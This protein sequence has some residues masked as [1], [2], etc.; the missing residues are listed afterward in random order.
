MTQEPITR[1]RLWLPRTAAFLRPTSEQGQDRA[2]NL[3]AA[4]FMLGTALVWTLAPV[5]LVISDLDIPGVSDALGLSND[6]GGAGDRVGYQN[7]FSFNAGWRMGGVVGCL[8]FLILR[9]HRLIAHLFTKGGSEARGKIAAAMGLGLRAGDSN[10][11]SE[12]KGRNFGGW[13]ILYGVLGKF[14]YVLLAFAVSYATVISL[15]IVTIIYTVWPIIFIVIMATI[16]KENYKRGG[17][18]TALMVLLCF[19]G[20]AFAGWHYIQAANFQIYIGVG[21]AVLAALLVGSHYA[22][23]LKWAGSLGRSLKDLGEQLQQKTGLSDSDD[24]LGN[25]LDIFAAGSALLLTQLIC[26]II[27]FVVGMRLGEN[28]DLLLLWFVGGFLSAGV[29]DILFRAANVVSDN[30][31]VNAIIYAMPIFALALLAIF[32]PDFAIK[33]PDYFVI[34]VLIIIVSN[35]FINSEAE[36][37]W[38]FRSLIFTLG[39]CG[40]FVYFRGNLFDYIGLDQWHWGVVEYFGVVG[41][42]ATVFTLLLAFRIGRIVARSDAEENRLFVAFRKL[43]FLARRGVIDPSILACVL[44][45]DETNDAQA[46]KEAYDQA[47]DYIREVYDKNIQVEHT[48]SLT[49]TSAEPAP[50]PTSVDSGDLQML[51][52]AEADLDALVRSR[53]S[54]IVLGELF[55]LIIFG[56]ITVFL[57]LFSRPQE[58]EGWPNFLI[59]LFAMLIAPVIVFLMINIRDLHNERGQ[60]WLDSID[61]EIEGEIKD[62]AVKLPQAVG[63]RA[64]QWLAVILGVGIVATY[65]GLLGNKWLGWFT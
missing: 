51:V 12:S 59:D 28:T 39:I 2:N 52:D 43:H 36:L 18:W 53:Q 5:G 11:S 19:V 10:D 54:A 6:P 17:G 48:R 9:Y 56:G 49:D 26:A 60:K 47:R 30:L 55:S 13:A 42:A 25:Q 40:T 64:D 33:Q 57:V 34:G 31:G 44:K 46:L 63:R 27:S 15:P 45:I 35:L 38:G 50:A 32:F 62:Y 65:M 21:I 16:D 41:M 1:S 23:M 24:K 7:P 22:V 3:L 37:H 8:L 20:F 14:D 4:G 61:G 29:G 58:T